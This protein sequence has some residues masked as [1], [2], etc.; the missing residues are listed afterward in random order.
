MC[1]R[2]N[3]SES[4]TNR[5]IF[6]RDDLYFK[7]LLKACFRSIITLLVYLLYILKSH[8]GKAKAIISKITNVWV[9]LS[10]LVINAGH[11]SP[12]NKK[13]KK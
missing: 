2:V 7:V 4:V 3:L 8:Y 13:C 9:N 6:Q 12:H 1:K 5:V 10:E 11:I